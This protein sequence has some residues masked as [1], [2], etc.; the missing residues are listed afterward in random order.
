MSMQGTP[1]E[2][3]RKRLKIQIFYNSISTGE[4]K[5]LEVEV[6]YRRG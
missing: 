3:F 1:V 5:F 2:C 4:P 6:L